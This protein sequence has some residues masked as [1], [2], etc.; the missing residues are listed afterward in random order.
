MRRVCPSQKWKQRVG[1][2]VNASSASILMV[3]IFLDKNLIFFSRIEIKK[4]LRNIVAEKAEAGMVA[5]QSIVAFVGL[6]WRF[7]FLGLCIRLHPNQQQ[8][9]IQI[10]YFGT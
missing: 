9:H 10:H 1:P 4:A 6:D 7:F 2:R 8:D 3:M 5:L